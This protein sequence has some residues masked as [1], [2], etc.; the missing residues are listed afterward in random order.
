MAIFLP[1]LFAAATKQKNKG[2]I[3][4]RFLQ[5]FCLKNFMDIAPLY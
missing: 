3:S 4:M 5:H 2:A 1:V